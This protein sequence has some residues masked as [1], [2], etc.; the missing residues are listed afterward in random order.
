MSSGFCVTNH[1]PTP[2]ERTRRT[3]CSMRS[4]SSFGRR[5]RA[6]APRRRR[7]RSGASP[8]R[9]PREAARRAPRGATGA[10]SRR[11]AA[12]EEL[13]GGEDVHHPPAVDGLHEVVEGEHRLAEEFLPP[14]DSSDRSPR[15]MAPM[16]AVECSRTACAAA[17][18][19]RPRAG[20]GRAGPFRSR[21]ASPLSSATLKTAARTPDWVSFRLRMRRAGAG[22]FP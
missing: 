13:V 16:L 7:R 6:G 20:A 1:T 21:S 5:R 3:T 15:W 9:P 14:W 19:C 18:R 22:P 4:R 8:G 11:R 12:R 10:S 17:R 2:L